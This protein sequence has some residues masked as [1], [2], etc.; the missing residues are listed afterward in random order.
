[1]TTKIHHTQH[2]LAAKM[3]GTL[4]ASDNNEGVVIGALGDNIFTAVGAK[5][6]LRQMQECYDAANPAAPKPKAESK[7]PKKAKRTKKPVA[8][9]DAEEDGDEVE[10]KGS[11]VKA[12]YKKKYQ[13]HHATCGDAFVAAL[14]AA[15]VNEDEAVDVQKLGVVARA[16]GLSLKPWLHLKNKDGGI[17]VGMIRMN[18]GNRLRG[19]VR[20]GKDVDIGGA[21]FKGQKAEP[22]AKRVR[23]PRAKKAAS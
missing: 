6:V 22:K 3:G 8:D 13:P 21:V 18:L 4:T 11:V 14:R 9:E 12:A 10:G 20:Q 1:M 2:K 5:E 16:N 17:N 7:A 19:M 23:K 15:T